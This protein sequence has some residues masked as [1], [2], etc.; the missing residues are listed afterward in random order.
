MGEREGGWED[1][2]KKTLSFAEITVLSEALTSYTA[3]QKILNR[4]FLPSSDLYNN[5]EVKLPKTEIRVGG[6]YLSLLWA[7][8]KHYNSLKLIQLPPKISEQRGKDS[9]LTAY[10]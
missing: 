3:G 7:K 4:S 9:I 8:P 2:A 10:L 6:S 5:V 1:S